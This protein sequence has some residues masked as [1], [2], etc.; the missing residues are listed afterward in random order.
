MVTTKDNKT[1]AVS[2]LLFINPENKKIVFEKIS[3]KGLKFESILHFDGLY[4][5]LFA[6]FTN[7]NDVEQ[8]GIVRMT[9]PSEIENIVVNIKIDSDFSKIELGD[10]ITLRSL[11]QVYIR[12]GF[13]DTIMFTGYLDAKG[14]PKNLPYL[15]K[16][17]KYW[18]D[19]NSVFFKVDSFIVLPDNAILPYGSLKS[20]ITEDNIE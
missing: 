7:K 19:D 9:Y 4:L 6:S 16:A 2:Y 3:K 13:D 11:E 1:T 15:W 18:N 12:Y 5:N 17:K 8:L 10:T 14:E 20:L